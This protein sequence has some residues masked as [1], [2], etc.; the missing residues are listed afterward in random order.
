MSFQ[1]PFACDPKLLALT[2]LTTSGCYVGA[3]VSA[4][5]DESR[6]TAEGD[7][8]ADEG[9]QGERASVEITVVARDG[10]PLAGARVTVGDEVWTADDDGRVVVEDVPPAKF[11]AIVDGPAPTP[12][13]IPKFVRGGLVLELPPGA[14]VKSRVTLVPHVVYEPFDADR[15]GT[16]ETETVRVYI[17]PGALVDEG[18]NPVIGAITPTI[19]P[20][21]PLGDL[22]VLP[23]PLR[24][25]EILLESVYMAEVTLWQD[26]EKLQLGDGMT[27]HLALRV[28]SGLARRHMP[29]DPMPAW[30]Y[31]YDMGTWLRAGV[32]G[33][34]H[35]SLGD[36]ALWWHVDL[37]HFSLWNADGPVE[38]IGCVDVGLTTKDEFNNVVPIVSGMV[39]LV[40]T[41]YNGYDTAVTGPDGHACLQMPRLC[42]G[43]LPCEADVYLGTLNDPKHSLLGNV[44][45]TGLEGACNGDCAEFPHFVE[46]DE[47]VCTPDVPVACGVYS[48]P[49]GTE[50]VGACSGPQQTCNGLG[51][52][53]GP[54]EEALPQPEADCL[55]NDD[56]DCDGIVEVKPGCG[57][58]DQLVYKCYDGTPGELAVPD[59]KACK[60]GTRACVG[61]VLQQECIGDNVGAEFENNAPNGVDDDCDGLVDEQD[62]PY[63]W[64]HGWDWDDMDPQTEIDSSQLATDV[65][66]TANNIFVAGHFTHGLTLAGACPS[67][68]GTGDTDLFVARFSKAGVCQEVVTFDPLDTVQHDVRIALDGGAVWLI[69]ACDGDVLVE[70]VPFMAACAQKSSFLVKIA[71]DFQSV[72]DFEPLPF[73]AAD[74][75]TTA[76]GGYPFIVGTRSEPPDLHLPRRL[77]LQRES[78]AALLHISDKVDL[79]GRRIETDGNKVY[80][81]GTY[82]GDPV[83]LTLGGTPRTSIGQGVFV[84]MLDTLLQAQSTTYL[85]SPSEDDGATVRALTVGL[86]PGVVA[87]AGEVTGALHIPPQVDA[88]FKTGRAAYVVA[89]D[90]AGVAKWHQAF[91][92]DGDVAAFNGLAF[93]P[94]SLLYAGGEYAGV[95]TIAGMQHDAGSNS[96]KDANMLLVQMKPAGGAATWSASFGGS[97]FRESIA[98]IAA[99]GPDVALAGTVGQEIALNANPNTVV[100][101][102]TLADIFLALMTP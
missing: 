80:V 51:T 37:P 24:A 55:D 21:N 83:D 44:V 72:T 34:F 16:I 10:A 27:A 84:T 23:G 93:G 31:D 45:G 28:P 48:G 88:A 91:A 75:S 90:T 38:E 87:V 94:D 9:D 99:N 82:E 92:T 100:D 65:L 59:P 33:T 8:V 96:V 42:D 3:D 47:D 81:A 73:L 26:G 30:F 95:L 79:D 101:W 97:K 70:G 49:N 64:A 6:I 12:G 69:G 60:S 32:D 74:I 57:C 89:F 58:D 62:N 35:T 40:G 7:D 29:L 54:C 77:V 13:E 53:Y 11:V 68:A 66:M 5:D 71:A 52:G 41:T 46:P 1:R 76:L 22:G 63:I 19:V 98:A 56:D 78:G 25:G 102:K 15:G 2:V 20:I 50:G 4:A 43:D 14:D 36:G 86:N 67:V 18:G 85:F 17:P 39:T 61:D